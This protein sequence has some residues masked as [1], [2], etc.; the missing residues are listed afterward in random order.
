[1]GTLN[2]T[3]MR[4]EIRLDLKDSG[5]LWSNGEID[6][7]MGRAVSDLS[8]YLPRE[9]IYEITLNFTV[10]TE[11]SAAPVVDTYVA[12]V[13]KPIKEGSETITTSPAGTTYTRD[14]DYT[15]DYSNGKYTIISTG[16]I[17]AVDSLLVTY[18]KSKT[19]IDISSLTTLIR[20]DKVVYPVGN[21]PESIVSAEVFDNKLTITSDDES[22]SYMTDGKHVAVYYLGTHTVPTATVA[23]SFP[24]FLDMTVEHAAAAYCLL[25]KAAQHE[26]QAVTDIAASRT[27]LTNIV[28]VHA[29]AS[30]ALVKVA[31]YLETNDTTDNAKDVLANITDDTAALRTAVDTALSAANAY[32]D[33]V[34]T[35][36]LQGAEGIWANETVYVTGASAPSG[37]KYLETGDDKINIVNV[38]SQVAALN[39]QYA[40][41]SL[42]IAAHFA[43]TRADFL[44]EANARTNA[45]IGY[46]Q[47]A[48][49]R[50]AN[51]RTYIEEAGGWMNMGM[52]FIQEAAQ[53]LAQIDRYLSEA[54]SQQ[55]IAIQ[56]MAISDRFRQEG[57]ERRNE[58]YAIW[59]DPKQYIGDISVSSTRQ[60]RND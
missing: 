33:E 6:R 7:C 37:K 12:L 35:T 18:T 58:V 52:T 16:S 43:Q 11:A 54:N 23:G 4:E 46:V 30:A 42:G 40:S 55:S 32:L 15:M 45:A 26:H 34:D 19:T 60:V 1:M 36:D 2:L 25:M 24:S 3:S 9:Q 10:T 41:T 50:L 47:E 57:L 14:T 13:H 20:V 28:A 29:L 38:G 59:R 49:Q 39:A 27:A 31:L 53:L 51:L 56:S 5:T 21:M 48:V 44:T 17:T 8:R 22:Q